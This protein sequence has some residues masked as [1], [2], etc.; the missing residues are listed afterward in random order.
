MTVRLVD[1]ELEQFVTEQVASGQFES[2]DAAVSAAVARMML[3]PS[4][5]MD[6]ELTAEDMAEIEEAE[7]DI[8]AGRY[9]PAD[10]VFAELL[11]EFPGEPKA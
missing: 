4:Q 3:D 8:A 1:P 7:R 2:V 10:E 11:R 5:E 9:R 6:D